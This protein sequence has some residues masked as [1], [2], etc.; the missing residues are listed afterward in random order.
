MAKEH[1]KYIEPTD[2]SGSHKG[3]CITNASTKTPPTKQNRM[4]L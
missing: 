1:M 3:M 2:Y 4:L